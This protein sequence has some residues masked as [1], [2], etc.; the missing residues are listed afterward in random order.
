[1]PLAIPI[2][3]AIIAATFGSILST[4][5][6]ILSEDQLRK[7]KYLKFQPDKFQ[8]GNKQQR[9]FE[10]WYYN[11]V[12]QPIRV[13][14]DHHDGRL[15]AVENNTSFSMAVVPGIFYSDASISKNES[16]AFIFVTLNGQQQHYYRFDVDQFT[17]AAENEEYYIQVGKNRFT[18][19]GVSLALYHQTN[20]DR[21][22][23]ITTGNTNNTGLRTMA[24]DTHF[25]ST[26]Q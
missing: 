5:N 21:T 26:V 22:T 2:L 25:C 17:Y 20:D 16:H 24:T 15:F 10:G 19:Y 12:S 3:T 9:Y 8:G 23:R 18:K 4:T 13:P 14:S 1:M 7:T 11:F 6:H